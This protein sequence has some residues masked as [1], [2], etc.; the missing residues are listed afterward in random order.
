MKPYRLRLAVPALGSAAREPKSAYG[1]DSDPQ[2]T[3]YT[4]AVC[5]SEGHMEESPLK[6]QHVCINLVCKFVCSSVCG[7]VCTCGVLDGCFLFAWTPSSSAYMC[8]THVE[9][10]LHKQ[11]MTRAI[12]GLPTLS[13]QESRM[14]LL[15]ID[16]LVTSSASAR[17]STVTRQYRFTG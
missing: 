1:V 12:V 2:H 15:T 8:S 3:A 10:T 16:C 11:N 6:K 7:C 5:T 14:S 13:A 4:P 17:Q 9:N